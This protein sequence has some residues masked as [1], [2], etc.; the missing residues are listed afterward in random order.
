MPESVLRPA[1]VST[2]TVRPRSNSTACFTSTSRRASRSVL[3]TVL[4]DGAI[5]E[6]PPAA[7]R[8]NNSVFRYVSDGWQEGGADDAHRADLRPRRR[9][10]PRLHRSDRRVAAAAH[11]AAGGALH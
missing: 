1:P 6:P 5:T 7:A 3:A 2:A 10:T 11:R 8:L 4:P 9:P